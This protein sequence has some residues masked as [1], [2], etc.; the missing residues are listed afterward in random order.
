MQD[1][2]FKQLMETYNKYKERLWPYN[3]RI[4]Q[5]NYSYRKKKLWT[6]QRK[7]IRPPHKETQKRKHLEPM[8]LSHLTGHANLSACLTKN[9]F[10]EIMSRTMQTS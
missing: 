1:T 3:K 10:K 7:R 8:I 2:S 9:T 6:V 4:C 5:K